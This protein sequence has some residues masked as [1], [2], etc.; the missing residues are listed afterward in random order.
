[1]CH[2]PDDFPPDAPVQGLLDRA[3]RLTLEAADGTAFAATL[4]R[5]REP[6]AAGIVVVP[7][8]R[9]LHPFY[10]RLAEQYAQAG[11]HALAIDQYARTAGVAHRGADFDYGPLIAAAARSPLC[12]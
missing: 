11:V 5:T 1:M 4:A 8:V 9:G 2:E 3:E 12:G 6:S 10:E 7:D